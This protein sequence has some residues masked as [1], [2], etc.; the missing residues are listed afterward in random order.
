MQLAPL[1]LRLRLRARFGRLVKQR[2]QAVVGARGRGSRRCGDA[3][4]AAQRQQKL[5]PEPDVGRARHREDGAVALVRRVGEKAWEKEKGWEE[6]QA[7][8]EPAEARTRSLYTRMS[9]CVCPCLYV[10]PLNAR[11]TVWLHAL[12]K[13]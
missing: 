13:A 1:Q 7:V 4:A 11:Q 8:Q 5:Q 9:V 2:L 6:R 12:E 10:S 3:A